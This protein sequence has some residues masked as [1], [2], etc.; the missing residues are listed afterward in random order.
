MDTARSQRRRH[1]YFNQVDE[2]LRMLLK[3]GGGF[4]QVS[5]SLSGRSVRLSH[6]QQVSFV[7]HEASSC[8]NGM[9]QQ[10]S[11]A[12]FHLLWSVFSQMGVV[13]SHYLNVSKKINN[14]Y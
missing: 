11:P 9:D 13:L 5:V 8:L 4:G 1:L 3:R 7:W 10:W 14:L 6:D 2:V 12:A